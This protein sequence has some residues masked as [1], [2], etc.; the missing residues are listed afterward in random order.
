[1]ANAAL[2]VKPRDFEPQ[3]GIGKNR[4]EAIAQVLRTAMV[5]DFSLYF[6][7]LS[8]HRGA[9]SGMLTAARMTA[10]P[11]IGET[12]VWTREARTG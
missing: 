7:M 11:G 4:M 8:S 12:N 3:T 5:D 2:Q 6:K 1:M 10:P 9:G